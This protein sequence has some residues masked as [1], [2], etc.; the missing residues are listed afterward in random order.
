MIKELLMGVITQQEIL[1]YYNATLLFEELPNE[2]NGYV[3]YY[4]GINCI[5]VNKNR[6]YYKKKK[7]L[8]HWV[9]TY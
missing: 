3:F 1:N 9:S 5:I 4:R 2:V 6:S 7:T 8:L